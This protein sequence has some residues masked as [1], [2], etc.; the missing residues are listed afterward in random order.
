MT[1]SPALGPLGVAPESPGDIDLLGNPSL[2]ATH[3]AVSAA[4]MR[5][6]AARRHSSLQ[7][8]AQ[9]GMRRPEP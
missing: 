6:W 9:C 4:L 2:L 7:P 5:S 1:A 8:S 3:T